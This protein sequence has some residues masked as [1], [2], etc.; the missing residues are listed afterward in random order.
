MRTIAATGAVGVVTAVEITECVLNA[1]A[2]NSELINKRILFMIH[3]L[4]SLR[5]LWVLC[6]PAVKRSLQTTAETLRAPR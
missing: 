2:N 5:I 4:R 6:E 3:F 1:D